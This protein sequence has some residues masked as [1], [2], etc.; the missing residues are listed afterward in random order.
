VARA[1]GYPA[2]VFERRP[3]PVPH[4]YD[5]HHDLLRLGELKLARYVMHETSRAQVAAEAV[6]TADARMWYA[7]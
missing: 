3:L 5:S 6:M 4:P 1:L 7:G 2:V